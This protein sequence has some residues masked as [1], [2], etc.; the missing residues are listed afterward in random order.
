MMDLGSRVG[1]RLCGQLHWSWEEDAE[2]VLKGRV[3]RL[4]VANDTARCG[5]MF[6]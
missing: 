4:Y 3:Q 1:Y 2:L 6:N 5:L